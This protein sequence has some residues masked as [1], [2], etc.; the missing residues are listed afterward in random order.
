MG[1]TNNITEFFITL[2]EEQYDY[3]VEEKDI[4]GWWNNFSREDTKGDPTPI[5]DLMR[6]ESHI[7]DFFD[8][9][10]GFNKLN[11]HLKA[12]I[13]GDIDFA[14]LREWIKDRHQIWYE[15]KMEKIN[16]MDEDLVKIQKLYAK[17]KKEQLETDRL[18]EIVETVK[19]LFTILEKEANLIYSVN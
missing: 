10:E 4:D 17:Y 8:N 1:D 2:L 9:D 16:K 11:K 13:W 15:E 7:E 19:T 18:D 12:A 3:N 5:W 6:I 14:H